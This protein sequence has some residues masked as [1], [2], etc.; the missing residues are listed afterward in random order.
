VFKFDKLMRFE[1]QPFWALWHL[2]TSTPM[3]RVYSSSYYAKTRETDI[4]ARAL[5]RDF[6]MTETSG[7]VNIFRY[8]RSPLPRGT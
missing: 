7:L 4:L 2:D 1:A 8:L 3:C 5:S 6:A